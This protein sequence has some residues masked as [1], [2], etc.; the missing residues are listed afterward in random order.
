MTHPLT[1][2]A[3]RLAAVELQHAAYCRRSMA[4]GLM[5]RWIAI[6]AIRQSLNQARA[7]TIAAQIV[8]RLA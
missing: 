7:C 6:P 3:R 1:Q 8:G 4:R 2:H 5:A